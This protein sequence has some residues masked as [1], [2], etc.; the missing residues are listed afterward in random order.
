MSTL[1]QT[2]FVGSCLGAGRMFRNVFG[3]RKDVGGDILV[4][5]RRGVLAAK[6]ASF[7]GGGCFFLRDMIYCSRT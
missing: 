5:C 4:V 1:Y 2:F 7:E 3:Q 6:G